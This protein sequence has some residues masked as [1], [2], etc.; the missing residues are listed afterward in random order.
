LVN[1]GDATAL[2]G[3]MA[4]MAYDP[5]FRGDAG[6]R[7]R[8]FAQR[9]LSFS[10]RMEESLSLYAKVVAETTGPLTP[11]RRRGRGRVR[12]EILGERPRRRAGVWAAVLTPV[13]A[14]AMVVALFFGTA[15]PVDDVTPN[16][17]TAFERVHTSESAS[18]DAASVDGREM[19]DSNL[20]ESLSPS[21][22]AASDER[23][24]G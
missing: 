17:A 8:E 15:T 14:L 21:M 19:D 20:D 1:P 22:F 2:T 12:E 16:Q 4:I 5:V 7:G 9:R 6:K 13:S 11:R 23:I 3:A 24:I 18:K 10:A